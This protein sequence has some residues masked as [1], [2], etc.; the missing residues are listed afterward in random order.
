VAEGAK[1]RAIVRRREAA[2]ELEREGVETALG[3]LADAS[4]LRAAAQGARAVVHVAA[5][6]SEDGAEALRINAEAT[7]LLAEAAL[8]AGCERFVHISTIA[9]YDVRGL[10]VVG[11]EAPLVS[12]DIWWSYATSKAEGDRAVSSAM[13]R[14]LHAVILRP[15]VVLGAHPTSTWGNLMPRAIAAGQFPLVA[16][17]GGTFPYVH[18]ENFVDAVLA[19]LRRE[20]AVGQAFNIIDGQTTWG[21]YIDVFRK[22][23]LPPAPEHP[24]FSF[25]ACGCSFPSDKARRL[26]GYSPTRT[27]DEAMAETVAFIGAS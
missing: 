20:E 4:A 26:L 16:G 18:V 7:A 19:S 23:P 15:G 12:G 10:D 2:G 14:G 22:G 1:V 3:D 8:A 21:R 5:T 24:M 13:A 9:A 27:F 11:E 25:F 6:A 17:G